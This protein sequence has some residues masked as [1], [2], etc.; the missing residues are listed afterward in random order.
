[1]LDAGVVKVVRASVA[2]L[3]LFDVPPSDVT[4]AHVSV[5]L[6]KAS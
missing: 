3:Q 4:E 6:P 5:E 2:V 1:M